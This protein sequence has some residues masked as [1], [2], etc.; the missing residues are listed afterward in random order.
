MGL[1]AMS[2]DRTVVE[3]DRCL[4]LLAGASPP[5]Y[6]HLKAYR[7]DVEWRQ[8]RSK[9]K[10]RGPLGKDIEVMGWRKERIVPPWV[11]MAK[12]SDAESLLTALF[13]GQVFLPKEL[14]DGLTKLKG[15]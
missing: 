13:R 1:T 4:N 8:V 9:Y 11:D 2:R 6:R 10:V 7:C 12:V 15:G 14:W 3:L 5:L